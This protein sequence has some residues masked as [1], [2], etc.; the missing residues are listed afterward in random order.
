MR[1]HFDLVSAKPHV[2]LDA[3]ALIYDADGLRVAVVKKGHVQ[4]VP[5]KIVRDYGA[6]VEIGQGLTGGETV[7]LNPPVALRDGGAVHVAAN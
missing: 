2:R 6:E 3:N 4:L 7:I 5:V 1:V